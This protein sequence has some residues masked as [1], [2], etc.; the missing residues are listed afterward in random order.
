MEK[1]RDENAESAHELRGLKTGDPAA[2]ERLWADYFHRLVG[3]AR[4]ML[5]TSA[6]RDAD[7]EDVAPALSR[8]CARVRLPG[9]TLNWTT[10]TV[11]GG[12]S[13]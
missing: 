1:E 9:S 4:T 3:L 13:W 11:S 5:P 6:R 10:A 2:I 12:C 7:E 8:A